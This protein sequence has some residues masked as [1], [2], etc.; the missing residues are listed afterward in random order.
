MYMFYVVGLGNPGEKYKNT[1]HNVG[2][3]LLDKVRERFSFSSLH[4]SSAYSGEV[5]EGRV[6]SSDVTALYPNTF[7][8]NSGAAVKKLVPKGREHNLVVIHDDIDL[9]FGEIKIGYGKG[10]GGNNGVQSIIDALGTK[11]FIR[12]RIGIAPMSFWTKEAVRPKGGGPLERFVLKQ[13]SKK[14]L[15]QLE[16]I[17]K[18]A[19]DV[20][21]AIV[22]KGV[23]DAMNKFN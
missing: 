6:G 10:A 12:I 4:E 1:R 22:E 13:F 2:W 11:E 23:N 17:S 8:N 16:D 19:T 18:K 15:Q 3:F 20:L 21:E 14:E 9:A 5:A 7:M